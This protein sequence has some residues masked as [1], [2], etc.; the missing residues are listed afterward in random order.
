LEKLVFDTPEALGAY[1]ATLIDAML[2]SKP[3]ALLCISAGDTQRPMFA[4][5][6]L[7]DG[8]RRARLYKARFILLDEWVGLSDSDAGGCGHFM[9]TQLFEPLAIPPEQVRGFDATAIDLRAQCAQADAW[10]DANG[11]I[12]L[13][14][15]GV[16][17]NGHVGFNEPGADTAERAHSLVLDAV[18]QAVGQKYFG[19]QAPPRA[20]ITLG[21][22]DLLAARRI[23]VQV[24]GA[25]KAPVV[26]SLTAAA[27]DPARMAGDPMVPTAAR[28]LALARTQLLVDRAADTAATDEA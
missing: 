27:A 12:D 16:G 23:V 28:F 4:A 13:L 19:G 5:L 7:W 22:R 3:D 1:S 17:M 2:Q 10:L 20:G 24:T 18:T 14:M 9:R 15:L 25:L 8:P 26:R 11:P 21:L 6:R